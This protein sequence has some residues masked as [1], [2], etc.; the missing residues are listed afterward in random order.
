MKRRPRIDLGQKFS[1]GERKRLDRKADNWFK[2]NEDKPKEENPFIKYLKPYQEQ[3]GEPSEKSTD[4]KSRLNNNEYGNH[5][6]Y[7]HYR[8]KPDN[9]QQTTPNVD[10][11]ADDANGKISET[12][13]LPASYFDAANKLIDQRLPLFKKEWFNQ[14]LVLDI[15]CN[16]GYITYAIARDFSPKSI[17]GID[18]DVKLVNMANRDLHL[19]LEN[20]ILD[21]RRELRLQQAADSKLSCGDDEQSLSLLEDPNQFPISEYV[22]HGPISNSSDTQSSAFPDN[23]IFAEHNYVLAT[24][25]LV[26]KQKPGFDTIICLS[27]TKWIHLNYRDEGIKRF[28]KRIYNHLNPDGLLILEAQPFS[29]YKRSKSLT[30]R[31]RTNYY[32]IELRPEM[33]EAY[34]LSE[35]VGFKEVIY[36]A[37]TDHQFDGFKRSMKVFKK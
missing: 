25:E 22:N 7:Y 15:G 8:N 30:D 6:G 12:H 1:E 18:I 36:D 28:F 17:I 5:P 13:N 29:N 20:G 16:R 14:K 19:H 33:F 24:D 31:L 35:E 26:N 21:K 27:V 11:K 2:R 37:L 23:L 32:S 3:Y 10:V 34:L 9:S 4:L